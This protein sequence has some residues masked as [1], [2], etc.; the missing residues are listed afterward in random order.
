MFQID[1]NL[2]YKGDNFGRFFIESHMF[3]KTL[4]SHIDKT[5]YLV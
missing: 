1:F 4:K 3:K 2:E 5:I